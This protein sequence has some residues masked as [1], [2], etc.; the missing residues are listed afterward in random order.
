MPIWLTVDLVQRA[1]KR[2]RALEGHWRGTLFGQSME[3]RF[4]Y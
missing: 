4:D 2:F 1:T 3:L